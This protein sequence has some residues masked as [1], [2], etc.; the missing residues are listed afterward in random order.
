MPTLPL[1]DLCEPFRAVYSRSRTPLAST[2]TTL[3][4]ASLISGS[5]LCAICAAFA[6]N[7]GPSGLSSNR[8]GKSHP[9]DVPRFRAEDVAPG[10]APQHIHRWIGYLVR[11]RTSETT[12]A[13]MI[14]FRVPTSTTPANATIA[15][16]NSVLRIRQDVMKLDRLNKPEGIND[17]HRCQRR[18]RQHRRPSGARNNMV[19]SAIAAVT[20]SANWV[21]APARAIDR[22]L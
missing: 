7:I 22:R 12:M 4:R 14:P 19:T 16:E 18:V 10:L 2:A 3:G 6:K 21:R 17:H 13:T 15:Q 11:Q 5:I 9:R 1:R 8:P 20:I